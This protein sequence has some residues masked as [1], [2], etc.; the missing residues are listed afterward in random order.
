MGT[1]PYPGAVGFVVSGLRSSAWRSLT[2]TG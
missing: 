1:H 2:G